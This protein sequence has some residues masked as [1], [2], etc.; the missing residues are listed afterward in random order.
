MPAPSIDAYTAALPA[1]LR[2][3]ATVLRTLLDREIGADLGTIWH[4]HPVWKNGARPLAGFKAYSTHV[5]FMIWAGTAIT[6][7]TKRLHLSGSG[8][9][10]VKLR[11]PADLDA[12]TFTEW[13]RQAAHAT[14]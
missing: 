4:A 13:L 1:P 9:G 5:T 6:D 14:G 11:T 3:V 7:P 10:S 8:M 2:D 12:T